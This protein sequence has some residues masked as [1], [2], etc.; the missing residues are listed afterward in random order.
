M[1]NTEKQQQSQTA[2]AIDSAHNRKLQIRKVFRLY[3]NTIRHC[4]RTKHVETSVLYA[5][6]L[7]HTK[8]IFRNDVDNGLMI[9]VTLDFW[10]KYKRVQFVLC[11]RVAVPS[12]FSRKRTAILLTITNRKFSFTNSGEDKCTCEPI[13]ASDNVNNSCQREE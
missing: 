7:R 6:A 10:C 2:N 11:Q 12:K 1:R 4:N 13:V 9:I 3:L 5:A 8:L